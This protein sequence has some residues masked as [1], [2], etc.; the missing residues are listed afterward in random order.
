MYFTL[1]RPAKH[2]VGCLF[3]Y[4]RESPTLTFHP[5]ARLVPSCSCTRRFFSLSDLAFCIGRTD[6]GNVS[7]VVSTMSAVDE[8]GTSG[9]WENFLTNG[10]LLLLALFG[11]LCVW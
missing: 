8:L 4:H 1:C 6:C 9:P 10:G 3:I 7:T 11:T 2:N 5:V